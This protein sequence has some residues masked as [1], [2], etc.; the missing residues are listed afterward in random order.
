MEASLAWLA[1]HAFAWPALPASML[2]TYIQ[3]TVSSALF[4]SAKSGPA[5]MMPLN[6][7]TEATLPD[8]EI[9]HRSQPG[10]NQTSRLA[11]LLAREDFGGLEGCRVAANMCAGKERRICAS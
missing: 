9:D 4:L 1:G 3:S 5:P 11:I 2:K 7:S 6:D 8:A 10:P